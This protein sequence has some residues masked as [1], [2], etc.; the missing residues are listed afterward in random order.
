[1]FNLKGEKKQNPPPIKNKYTKQNKNLGQL[2]KKAVDI[3]F[4]KVVI[5]T[6]YE[7]FF[8]N[9]IFNIKKYDRH[10]IT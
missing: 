5:C 3:K 1:M 8:I 6:V 7:T 10:L 4:P 2:V 9:L